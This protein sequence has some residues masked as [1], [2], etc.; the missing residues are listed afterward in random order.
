MAVVRAQ[1]RSPYSS[2]TCRSLYTYDVFLSFRG[3]D[4]RT[5]FTDHLYAALVDKGIRT[6]R[7]YDEIEKGESLKPELEKAIKESRISLIV[8]SKNYATSRWCLDEL[9]MILECRKINSRHVV[10]P[11]FYDVS[12][13]EVRKQTG[14]IGEAFD[15]YKEELELMQKVKGWRA[16]LKEV[17][18]LAG[19]ELKNQANRHEAEFIKEIIKIIEDKLRRT[20]LFV[21]PILIGMHSRAENINKWLQDDSSKV[22]FL[23]ICGM[24]GIG[25]TT[26]AKFVYDENYESFDASCFLADIREMSRKLDGL[27]GLQRQLLSSIL[28]KKHRKIYNTHE[29]IIKI[30][31]AVSCKRVLL[32]LDDVDQR[33]QLDVLRGTEGSFHPGSKIIITTR[34]ERL[35]KP[36]DQVFKVEEL[37]HDESVKLFS[38]YAF[39][40]DR[41]IEGYAEHTESIVQ[42]CGGLPLALHVLG[43]SLSGRTVPEWASEVKK[44]QA[45]PPSEILNKLKISYDCLEE[46]HDKRLFL[47]IACFF[48]GEDKDY[49]IKVL[50]STDTHADVRIQNLIDRSLLTIDSRNKLMMHQLIRDMGRNIVQ[51]ESD[52]EPGER[53]RLWRQ[54]DAYT[55]LRY[56]KGT[57]IIEGLTLDMRRTKKDDNIARKLRYDKSLNKASPL[58]SICSFF[59]CFSCFLLGQEISPA[60]RN[61]SLDLSTDAFEKMER[62][63]L[64]KLNY[65]QLDGWYDNFPK[66]LIWL[67]WHGFPSKYMPI[68]LSLE[69][70]VA[71]DLRH[72]KLEEVW[73]GPK[74]LGSLKILN[75]S[76]SK[77]LVK[78]PN[79]LGVPN[80]ER[81][82]LKGCVR[83][84]EICESIEFL[85]E[86]DLL[87]L[88]DCKNLR[89]LPRNM[90][91]LGSLEAL[92][93]SGC[94]AL[95]A[96]GLGI[97]A[98]STTIGQ[99]RWWCT[100]LLLP[101]VPQLGR[102]S[103]ILWASL[104]HSLSNL[105][106]A[107]CNL[108]DDSL[109]SAFSNLSGLKYLDLS[110]NSFCSLPDCIKSLSSLH[111]LS[112][113]HCR[114]LNSILGLPS[115]L[116][117]L[118]LEWCDSLRKITFQ[119][120]PYQ[121]EETYCFDCDRLV[122]VDGILKREPVGEVDGRIIKN[123]GIDIK[124][125][126]KLKGSYE[127]GIFSTFIPGGEIPSCFSERKKGSSMPFT[128]SLVPKFRVQ[129]LIICSVY[130]FSGRGVTR[131]PFAIKINNR[132]KDLSWV[133]CPMYYGCPGE[134][135]EMTWLSQWNFR[136]KVEGG[137][138]IVVSVFLSEMFEVKE[139]GIKIVYKEEGDG[140]VS[141][142]NYNKTFHWNEVVG[143][144]LSRLELST[145][146]YFLCRKLKRS[147]YPDVVIDIYRMSL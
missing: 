120:T 85:E 15:R 63:R 90:Y 144:D 141:D 6:F 123:W 3:E 73:A 22:I 121:L 89:K 104:P 143:R 44:L 106:L 10:L 53:S 31:E 37:G 29:G 105:S 41:T 117:S 24:G 52:D 81:L 146:A 12:P 65:T 66:K 71:L 5:N 61:E 80:L 32:V 116:R 55:V 113:H 109:P 136:N 132:T 42:I 102:G 118:N 30:K 124:S 114:S 48:V 127:F 50:D 122:E 139:C 111:W 59:N 115:N 100:S 20:P 142:D 33:D 93:I 70:L 108:S 95:F 49:T 67:C 110:Y 119:S 68:E 130:V 75:L 103:E 11:V 128:V 134:D 8:F 86:L 96:G 46:Y 147:I 60:L 43:A 1:E 45:I 54:E 56:K 51:Q 13:S 25:K 87:D 28:N 76:Y 35:L 88:T 94:S 82:I 18:D 97:G 98:T 19:M 101:W 79:F 57:R 26:I 145:R 7:D 112:L 131:Y 64:L 107:W 34:N 36:Y 140:V 133:Y 135:E 2:S 62:L 58:I 77:R 21:A 125:I 40:K 91:K 137:D 126:E 78:T 74:F 129:H 9:V 84:I 17:A 47:D 16:T 23:G 14:T 69:N 38:F 92:I 83:L 27:V 39:G 4:T 99:G 72:S 138:K